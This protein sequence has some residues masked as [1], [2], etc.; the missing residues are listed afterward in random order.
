[1]SLINE[2]LKKAARLRAEEQAD[3]V[4]PMPG[5]GHGRISAS[6]SRSARRPWSS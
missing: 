4:P 6:A 5:G 1:M 2:A 3:M